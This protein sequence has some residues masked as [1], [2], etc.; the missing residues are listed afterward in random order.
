[1]RR[2][3]FPSLSAPTLPNAFRRLAWS[4]LTAQS[5]EQI[6]LAAA[7]IVAVLSLGA[8]A[9][10]TG[11]LAAMQTLPFLLLSIPAG[12][13]ADRL[14]RRTLMV[15]AE[16]T[17]ALALLCV[18]WLAM[19]GHL[20][21]TLLAILGFAIATGTVV[22]SV[23]APSLVPALVPR[24]TLTRANGQLELARSAAFTAG[25]A[26]AGALAGW[27]GTSAAFLLAAVLSI[28]AVGLL[29]GVNEPPRDALPRRH[30]WHDLRE[31]AV[32]AWQHALLR[33]ILMTSLAWNIAWFVL[34][35]AYVPYAVHDLGIGATGVGA[36]LAAY[37]AGMVV[38]AWGAPRLM[39]R[40]A[41]GMSIV[42]GPAVSVVAAAAIAATAWLPSRVAAG[43]AGLAFFL[44][45]AGPMIWTI[46]QTTLRQTVVPS[47]MLGRVSALFMTAN[48]GARPLGAAL[49]GMLGA[50]AGPRV[51][52]LVA[53]AAFVVQ[54]G[55]IL[56]SAV[57]ALEKLPDAAA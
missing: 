43:G 55:I 56:K 20:N 13:L 29:R 7:P 47:T 34:Q 44:F 8:G 19:T 24:E 53:A 54:A 16:S 41:F 6:S 22:F 11:W 40:L 23:A 33:P 26:L 1:M 45:G 49:G 30:P 37:G 35:A 36:T 46:S 50:A 39:Q 14:P 12:L 17:R 57:P 31:G 10:Q 5:A 51:C 9:G 18:P 2:F 38:G 42:T 48:T 25:P 28:I 15:L 4:N 21:V 52:V 32:L 3:H 27:A